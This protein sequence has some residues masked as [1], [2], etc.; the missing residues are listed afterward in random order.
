LPQDI[1][2]AMESFG[3]AMGIYK[4]QDMSG[5]DIAWAQRKARAAA[6]PAAERYAHIADRL[7][8][9]GRLGRKTGKGWYDYASG[10]AAI[11][12]EVQQ[13]I[14]EESAK[15]GRTRRSFSADE[16]MQRILSVMQSEGQ[17]ILN[18]GIA[19]SAADIDVVMVLGYGFPRH[20][21]GPMFMARA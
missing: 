10:A 4:V 9:A 17:A 5:L 6:R 18:E 11:D 1:D 2:A 12:P 21:G 20:K 19:E 8:K 3:F 13:I 14:E 15:A 16:I 7:C